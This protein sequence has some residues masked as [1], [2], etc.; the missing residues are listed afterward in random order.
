MVGHCQSRSLTEPLPPGVGSRGYAYPVRLRLWLL[1]P[2][3]PLLT[4]TRLY[5]QP[6]LGLDFDSDMPAQGEEITKDNSVSGF[7]STVK[8]DSRL[9]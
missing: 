5:S 2:E 7:K 6:N 3:L 4:Y 8:R 9:T 1:P